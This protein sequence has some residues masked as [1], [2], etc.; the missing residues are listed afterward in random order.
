LKST[1][2]HPSKGGRKRKEKTEEEERRRRK[3]ERQE[4]KRVDPFR[5]WGSEFGFRFFG[6][7]HSRFNFQ[8]H[9]TAAAAAH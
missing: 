1:P 2:S 7:R 5:P 3:K 9:D 4:E 6:S 8:P